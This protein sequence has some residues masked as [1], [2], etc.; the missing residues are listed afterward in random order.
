MCNCEISTDNI[1]DDAFG[2]G[3]HDHMITYRGRILGGLDYSALGLVELMQTWIASGKAYITI[4]SFRMQVDPACPA[5]LD[6]LN[7][8]DCPLGDSLPPG[9]MTPPTD[10]TNPINPIRST[11]PLPMGSSSSAV[12]GMRA[13]EVGGITIGV[14]LMILL[15]ALILLI[16]GIFLYKGKFCTLP[17]RLASSMT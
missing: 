11:E 6:A 15:I 7:A 16:L 3:Q 2:C 8:P 9:V 1:Q 4:D 5:R 17:S 12:Q 14:I 10:T 13:A